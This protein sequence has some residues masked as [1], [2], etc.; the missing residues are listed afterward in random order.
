MILS[1]WKLLPPSQLISR[2]CRLSFGVQRSSNPCVTRTFG[3]PLTTAKMLPPPVTRPD[4]R[5]VQFLT[6]FPLPPA[7][8]FTAV[9]V[10]RVI[11]WPL[12]EMFDVADT[13]VVP[14]ANDV[15]VTVQ[16]ALAAPP[17]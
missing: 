13:V 14:A 4:A 11:D 16:L 10:V 8:V 2:L 1:R 3:T 17:V 15:M 5:D 6:A 12:T 9:L 7:A